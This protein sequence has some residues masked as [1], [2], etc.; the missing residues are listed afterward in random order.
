MKRIKYTSDASTVTCSE[1]QAGCDVES[2]VVHVCF[3]D[4]SGATVCRN[5]FNSLLNEGKW[6][7]DECI[8]IKAA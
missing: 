8:T 4:G 7:T 5:C 6:I 2:G 3:E 1:K